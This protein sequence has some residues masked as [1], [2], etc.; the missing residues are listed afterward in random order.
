MNA[1]GNQIK[2]AE[3]ILAFLESIKNPAKVAIMHCR[4]HQKGKTTPELGNC[5]ADK[6]ARKIAEKGILTVI[7]QK[8]L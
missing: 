7:P 1:Q 8:D 6:A 5:F 4:G 2:H 3:Q